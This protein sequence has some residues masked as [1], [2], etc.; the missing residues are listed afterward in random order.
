MYYDMKKIIA[1]FVFFLFSFLAEAHPFHV[2]VCELEY[3][4]N[5]QRYELALKIFT[6]DFTKALKEYDTKQTEI[7]LLGEDKALQP[8]LE[9]YLNLYFIIREGEQ[10]LELSYV[11]K[12]GDE[13]AVWFYFEVASVAPGKALYVKNLI[14][15]DQFDDQS[16]LLHYRCGIESNSYMFKKSQNEHAISCKE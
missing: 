6:D 12:E 8:L 5:S 3:N 16:N 9:N 11:G 7:D 2:S 14:L 15:F 4:A 13:D 1:G 10:S